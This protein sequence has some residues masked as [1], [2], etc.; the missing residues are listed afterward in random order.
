MIAYWI[1]LLV[2]R[3]N[4]AKIWDIGE[5]Q[6][7]LI[8]PFLDELPIAQ[9]AEIEERAPVSLKGQPRDMKC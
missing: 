3:Q 9:L 1:S 8:K 7:V 2:I 5:I 6:Y 4:A